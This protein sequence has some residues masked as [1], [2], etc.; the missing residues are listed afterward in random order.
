MD[1]KIRQVLI[2]DQMD[3]REDG[4]HSWKLDPGLHASQETQTGFRELLHKKLQ[5]RRASTQDWGS[6][7]VPDKMNGTW[8]LPIRKK[9]W[10]AITDKKY[11]CLLCA[12]SQLAFSQKPNASDIFLSGPNSQP[13]SAWGEK[14][15]GAMSWLCGY[16]RSSESWVVFQAR[17]QDG[18]WKAVEC[19]VQLWRHNDFP[20]T[21]FASWRLFSTV[22]VSLQL[23]QSI[24]VASTSD[25]YDEL[26][27][28]PGELAFT[29]LELFT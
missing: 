25:K 14:E 4:G 2:K 27:S 23:M 28:A 19:Q 7:W 26:S 21:N 24:H 6:S 11:S 13:S 16:H 15:S 18:L 29:A 12:Q 17:A 5:G 22:A 8:S 20:G 9:N 10:Q 3:A 1:G